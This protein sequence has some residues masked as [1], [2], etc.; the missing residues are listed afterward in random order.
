MDRIVHHH[1]W[2]K[3]GAAD[4][5]PSFFTNESRNLANNHE[6]IYIMHTKERDLML[7]KPKRLQPGDK[8]ATVSPS[9]GGAGDEPLQWRYEQGVQ[10]LKDVFGLEV[11]AMPNSLKGSDYLY[12]HPEARAE[13]L[14]TAFADNSIKG[15]I[16]NIGGEESIR[17]LP[18][19]DFD[20]IHENPK[21]FM[22]YSDVTIAHLF[23]HKAG[24]SS[25]YGPAI[26]T[27]FAE[28][29]EMHPYTVNSIQQTLFSN[30]K[31]GEVKPAKEWT[32]EFLEWDI[33]N[34]DTRRQMQ[35][36][37]AYE[38]LQGNGVVQGRLIGGCMDVLEFAKGTALWPESSYW[39][40]SILFFETSEEQPKPDLIKYWLRNYAA[41]G[42]LQKTN[43]ILVA[44]PYDEMYYTEYKEAI[45]TVMQEYGLADLPILYNM[46]FG[47]TEPKFILPYG[48]QAE[49]D[50]NEANFSIIEN[51]VE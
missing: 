50:C 29:I 33:A 13:D 15:I 38:V 14:M 34:K 36:N 47:H 7:I 22:G 49:I 8:V 1:N 42:I 6:C 5:A 23:C 10:R 18:Y 11:V 25:F 12:A 51:A 26:L 31:V 3:E 19:I 32:S 44:K 27:D 9:W 2:I 37:S 43:G 30:E 46:N 39:E 40:E 28:N 21:I 16:A 48:V 35:P 4:E 41:Q 24:I 17:L 45:R 20:T